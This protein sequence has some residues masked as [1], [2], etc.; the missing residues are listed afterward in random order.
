MCRPT[1]VPG[2]LLIALSAILTGVEA[3]P[4]TKPRKPPPPSPQKKLMIELGNVQAEIQ[5]IQAEETIALGKVHAKYGPDRA[6]HA[7]RVAELFADLRKLHAEEWAQLKL[8]IDPTKAKA[9]RE[10]YATEMADLEKRIAQKAVKIEELT[11]KR[12][13]DIL[14][15]EKKWFE[16]ML[17]LATPEKK[18]AELN[19][20]EREALYKL[21]TGEKAKAIHDAY[22]SKIVALEKEITAMQTAVGEANATRRKAR[23]AVKSAL[24]EKLV[25]HLSSIIA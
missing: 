7:H 10:K 19:A 20:K 12:D 9:I 6:R 8:A 22:D 11:I 17:P 3:A 4:P 13:Q 15:A 21:F 16:A 25:P 14:A 1:F 18:L 24:S 5:K 2:V 23:A